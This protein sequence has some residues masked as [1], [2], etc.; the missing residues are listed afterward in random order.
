MVH[1]VTLSLRLV[2]NLVAKG[3]MKAPDGYLPCTRS[4]LI[5]VQRRTGSG[6]KV[7]K[8][9][10]TNNLGD[11]R[12]KVPNEPGRYRAV[13]PQGSVDDLNLCSATKSPVRRAR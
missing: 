10:Y 2:K 7:I 8:T 3:T 1:D 11:Y 12:A 6:W 4:A 5:K 9:V 13:S